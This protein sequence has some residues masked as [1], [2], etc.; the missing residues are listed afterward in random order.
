MQ[1]RLA[2]VILHYGEPDLTARL[3]H[4]LLASDPDWPDLFV[5]DNAAPKPYPDAWARLPENLYW[6]GALADTAERLEDDGFTHLWFLNNDLIFDC[7]PPILTTAWQRFLR[8]EKTLGKLG[9]YSPAALRNPYHPQMVQAPDRQYR[10]VTYLDGIAPLLNLECVRSIGGVDF[11]D[12]PYGYGVDIALTMAAHTAGW[13]LVVDHQ[14]AIRHTYHS[15]ARSID[16]FL[17]KAAQAEDAYM[18]RKVG[19]DWRDRVTQAGTDYT[20]HDRM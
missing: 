15:T 9:A 8:L 5:L 4:Q 10:R 7:K 20:D 16:G 1:S 14:I 2:V 18:R 11:T 17:K 3:H 12:N 19:N 13:P 6:A